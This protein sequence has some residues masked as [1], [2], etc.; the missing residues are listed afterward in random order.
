MKN[1]MQFIGYGSFIQDKDAFLYYNVTMD[2]PITT[3][4]LSGGQ[5]NGIYVSSDPSL[6]QYD[7]GMPDTWE[8]TTVDNKIVDVTLLMAKFKNT[9]NAGSID[10]DLNSIS[11]LAIKRRINKPNAVWQT[12][13]V[14]P[15]SDM[16]DFSFTYIDYLCK[17]NCEY[18]YNIVPVINETETFSDNI[19]SVK[20]QFEGVYFTDGKSQYGSTF[21]NES[22]YDRVTNTSTVQT[23]NS[24]YPTVIKN[25][26]INYSKGSLTT[27]F[28]KMDT[29]CE[30]ADLDNGFDYREEVINFLSDN[31]ALVFKNYD[32]FIAIVSATEDGTFSENFSEHYLAPK[33]SLSWIQIGDADDCNQL[34]QYGLIESGG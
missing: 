9:C 2:T 23:I 4:T 18:Q 14:C 11:G 26:C 22:S 16:S 20:S 30:F 33:L 19:V 31:H 32:G 10:I 34:R 3:I 28:L 7:N 12:L 29:S 5:I 17:N 1:N 13:Y 24:K 21:D 6:E 15:V 25:G 27:R 8:T